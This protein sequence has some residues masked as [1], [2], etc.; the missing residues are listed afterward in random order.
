MKKDS[1]KRLRVKNYREAIIQNICR[2]FNMSP[3]IAKAYY[4]QIEIY[5]EEHLTNRLQPGQITYEA[6]SKEEPAGKPISRCLKKA[7]VLT[8]NHGEDLELLEKQ[9]LTICRRK[10]IIRIA[11]EARSQGAYLTCEDLAV[12]LT[13]SESTIKRDVKVLKGEGLVVPLRGRMKDIGRTISHKVEVVEMLLENYQFTEIE[14][15]T[16]HSEKSIERYLKDFTQVAILADKKLS[17][18]E[19]RQ[20][21]GVSKNLV[22]EYL[23]LCESAM[24]D[25]FKRKKLREILQ[26]MQ[27]PVKKNSR[28]SK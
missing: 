18:Q 5:F 10:R 27:E 12:I 8:L 23:D 7:V 1:I 24:K 20:I 19:I 17:L 15:I 11:E 13:T 4:R 28:R 9:G 2:D 22:Q 26:Q 3:I 25:P 6:V 14:R 16:R 21:V